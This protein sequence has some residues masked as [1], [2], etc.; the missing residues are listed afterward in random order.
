VS[1][2]Q[3]GIDDDI[4][5]LIVTLVHC[6]YEGYELSA[7]VAECVLLRWWK[8]SWC[9]LSRFNRSDQFR[10]GVGCDSVRAL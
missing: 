1:G 3:N 10:W 7:A 5:A 4:F 6:T 9:L 8:K 2:K